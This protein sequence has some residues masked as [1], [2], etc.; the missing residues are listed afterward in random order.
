MSA[1]DDFVR[2][3][4]WGIRVHEDINP[5][6]NGKAKHYEYPKEDNSVVLYWGY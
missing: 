4:E 1:K 3:V 6:I 2:D 5:R